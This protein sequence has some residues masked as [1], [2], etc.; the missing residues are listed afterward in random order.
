MRLEESREVLK[1]LNL[2]LAMRLSQPMHQNWENFVREWQ[3]I[4]QRRTDRA[5]MACK[6]V[7]CWCCVS[8]LLL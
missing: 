4:W 5:C 3:K 6:A 7:F 2:V 8:L 1:K